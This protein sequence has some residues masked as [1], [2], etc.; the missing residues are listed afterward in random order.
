MEQI[1]LDQVDLE[2]MRILQ[3]DAWIST[4]QIGYILLKSSTTIHNRISRLKR[5]GFITGSVALIDHNKFG[6]LLTAF[7]NLTLTDHSST[8]LNQFQLEVI[9]FEEVQEC[10]H[11]TGNADFLVKV[12]VPNMRDYSKFL[13]EKLGRLPHVGA[14]QSGMVI[15]EVKRSLSFSVDKLNEIYG[16]NKIKAKS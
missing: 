13:S 16:F 8:A 12:A 4:K 6:D 11:L 2:I 10:F 5:F 7:V 9:K 15:Q 3:K 14:L 1:D